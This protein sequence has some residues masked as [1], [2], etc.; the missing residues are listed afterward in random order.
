L[1]NDPLAGWS[2]NYAEVAVVT[3][4]CVHQGGETTLRMDIPPVLDGATCKVIARLVR[5]GT[6][7]SL[8]EGL[9]QANAFALT[10]GDVVYDPETK[11]GHLMT[12]IG[13]VCVHAADHATARQRLPITTFCGIAFCHAGLCKATVMG[14]VSGND[15][16]PTKRS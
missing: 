9:R 1:L 16:R 8:A 4:G 5:P 12:A 3:T 6:C 13:W 11:Q 7:G 10:V 15:N 14:R 2:I